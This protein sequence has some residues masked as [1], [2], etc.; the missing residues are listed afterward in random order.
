MPALRSN[1]RTVL[2]A[3]ILFVA[4]IAAIVMI[5]DSASPGRSLLG[6]ALLAVIVWTAAQIPVVQLIR[7]TVTN[8]PRPR[9]L[10]LRSQTVQLLAEIRRL[11]GIAEDEKRGFRDQRTAELEMEAIDTRMRELLAGIRDV[12][13]VTSP[14]DQ[15]EESEAPTSAEAP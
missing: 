7:E 14:E 13:G 10:A 3:I 4:L 11:N 6:G 8:R 1:S 5:Y 9:F 2:L 12:A 15:A